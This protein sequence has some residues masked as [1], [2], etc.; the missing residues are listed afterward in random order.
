LVGKR[1]DHYYEKA[2]QEGYRS[3]AAYKLL[4]IQKR[5]KI[6]RKGDR[7]V[8]LGCAPGGWLQLI[9]A[10][11]GPKGRMVGVDLQKTR[12]LGSGNVELIQGDITASEVQSRVR[13][14]LG[15]EAH[16][17]TSDLSPNLTGIRFQDHM[18]S[19]ELVRTGLAVARELLRSGGIFL[20]K[21]FQGEELDAVVREL[22]DEFGEVRRVV[23]TASRKASSEIYLLAKG[24]RGAVKGSSSGEEGSA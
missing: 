9:A 13:Q 21:V 3:R 11:V 5:F 19:C 10:E 15:G 16:V 12:A 23:P 6:F 22:K 20:A 17:V 2:K 14:A 4:E 18:R 8:D 24:F 1:K 7:V